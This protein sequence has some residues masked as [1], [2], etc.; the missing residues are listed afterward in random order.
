MLTAIL[1]D[2]MPEAFLKKDGG[3]LNIKNNQTVPVAIG[4]KAEVMELLE[5]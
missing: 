3:Y 1:I 5:R 2:D 4:Y